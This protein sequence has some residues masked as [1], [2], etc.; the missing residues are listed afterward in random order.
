MSFNTSNSELIEFNKLFSDYQD[1]FIRFAITYVNNSVIAEDIVMDSIMYYW[2]NRNRLNTDNSI[3]AYIFT[4]IKNKCLNHLRNT[5]CH[6]SISKDL[7][8]HLEWKRQLQI[9]TLEACNPEELLAKEL[10]E[11][12]NRELEKLSPVTRKIFM[13]RRFENLS[14]KEVASAMNMSTKG[15]EYHMAKATNQLKKSLKDFLPILIFLLH[16]KL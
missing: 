16:H 10:Y 3:P 13:M 5:E 14:N 6:E 4:S 2:E 15:I 9:A 7:F 8:D 11:I 12:I 1:K